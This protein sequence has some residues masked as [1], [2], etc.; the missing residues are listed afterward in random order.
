MCLGR[1]EARLSGVEVS[2]YLE[3]F[4]R[5]GA[6]QHDLLGR[7]A[8]NERGQFL[9]KHVRHLDS[10][11]GEAKSP[12]RYVIVA[13]R[14]G[15][16]TEVQELNHAHDWVDL[17][18][19]DA[20]V[21]RGTVKDERGKPLVGALVHCNGNAWRSLSV[22]VRSAR[23]DALGQFQIDDVATVWGC[24]IEHPDYP[25]KVLYDEGT[26]L[27]PEGSRFSTDVLKLPLNVTLVKGSVVEGQVIDSVT[28]RPGVGET[29]TIQAMQNQKPYIGHRIFFAE[30]PCLFSGE[31]QT[32]DNG[33]YQFTR[34]PAGRFAIYLTSDI[35]AR[36]SI[37]LH[38]LD[39]PA[40]TA[41]HAPDIRLVKGGIVHGRLI[42]DQSG[43]PA[44]LGEN[45]KV[46]IK[47]DGP[48]RP[49]QNEIQDYLLPQSFPVA[50]DGTFQLRLPPGKNF[51]CGS[52]RP[53]FAEHPADRN[54]SRDIREIEIKDGQEATLEFRV[55][56]LLPLKRQSSGVT[57]DAPSSVDAGGA[58]PEWFHVR[59][60]DI[61]GIWSDAAGQGIAGAKVTL[62]STDADG[63]K[64]KAVKITTTNSWG[65]FL[66][67]CAPCLAG[68]NQHYEL[69]LS[70]DNE[71]PDVRKMVQPG[72]WLEL[73]ASP[74]EFRGIR[75]VPMK[76]APV[77]TITK[78]PAKTSGAVTRP[79][80]VMVAEA[81]SVS[82]KIVDYHLEKDAVG[83]L[84]LGRDEVRFTGV[85]VALYIIGRNDDSHRYIGRTITNDE[86]QFVF[87]QVPPLRSG[88]EDYLMVARK[89][90]LTVA[91]GTLRQRHDWLDLGMGPGVSMNGVVRDEQDKPI[92][93]ALVREWSYWPY[94]V[95]DE[96]PSARTNE[97]GEFQIDDL[98][99]FGACSVS[100]PDYLSAGFGKAKK[101]PVVATLRKGS[102]VEGQVI[103]GETGQPVADAL[104]TLEPIGHFAGTFVP[105]GA[106]PVWVVFRS[107]PTS[108]GD[109]SSGP[110]GP[111]R[112]GCPSGAASGGS[113]RQP[114]M[115]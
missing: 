46:T 59:G 43:Q 6:R 66:F 63:S 47:V 96:T 7:T 100:H 105:Q 48:A 56:R 24:V 102:F 87:R 85:E 93:N 10:A 3:S 81:P 94:G 50:K 71:S 12:E 83:G 45:E 67:V 1:G 23:T 9:F 54:A 60:G 82:P 13:R 62:I 18:M 65:Q 2:L 103:D 70:R 14:K 95:P 27:P 72:E 107:R 40:A 57:S 61:G 38:S 112:S 104:V 37:A 19:A 21:V 31:T 58:K 76:A 22:E 114:S 30:D 68:P 110:S 33:H 108:T 64:R 15:L 5:R 98:Q 53:Y 41:V 89:K 25:A 91:K 26:F 20:V 90:G 78:P 88:E 101:N 74:I 39:V 97:R 34:L 75:Q 52:G 29:V 51:V 92:A 115:R 28:R 69:V 11:S 77:K 42:D 32:D 111:A 84:C 4:L 17:K 35:P 113:R 79:A 99:Q 44:R 80:A 36:T 86:G 16:A 55:V 106:E 73:R 109:T 49:R 8:T